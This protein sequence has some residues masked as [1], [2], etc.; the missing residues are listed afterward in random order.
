MADE[1]VSLYLGNLR[2]AET[3]NS[4]MEWCM[5]RGIY[6]TAIYLP[7]DA[8]GSRSVGMAMISVLP[9]HVGLAIKM[10]HNYDFSGREI[11]CKVWQK[12]RD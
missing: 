12:P 4:I 9:G 5:L 3:K 2:Y 7:H 8:E 10:L 1:Y 6:P 11:V